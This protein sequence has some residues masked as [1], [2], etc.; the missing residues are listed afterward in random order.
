MELL[1][2]FSVLKKKKNTGFLPD[3]FL[4]P[5]DWSSQWFVCRKSGQVMGVACGHR[6][7]ADPLLEHGGFGEWECDKVSQKLVKGGAFSTE[8]PVLA[9]KC[10][11]GSARQQSLILGCFHACS[12]LQSLTEFGQDC[13]PPVDFLQDLFL[14][15]GFVAEPPPWKLINIPEDTPEQE[16][17]VLLCESGVNRISLLSKNSIREEEI[18]FL[19]RQCPKEEVRHWRDEE[20]WEVADARIRLMIEKEI[21]ELERSLTLLGLE[22]SSR[23]SKAFTYDRL[24]MCEV[25]KMVRE[26]RQPRKSMGTN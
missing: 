20:N 3:C 22:K 11:T 1:K 5:C 17:V 19:I 14:Y 2:K 15:C 10:K 9:Q 4:S 18:K 16:I 25:L 23:S 24:T 13:S 8:K 21:V 6:A 7:G 26:E 12:S